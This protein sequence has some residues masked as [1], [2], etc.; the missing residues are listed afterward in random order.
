MV[1]PCSSC[2][3]W[4]ASSIVTVG[5]SVAVEAQDRGPVPFVD[6]VHPQAVA[7]GH[8]IRGVRKIR[9]VGEALV[10]GR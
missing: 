9:Q 4:L 3:K 8:V 5:W 1:G 2:R 10:G 6:V 7:H